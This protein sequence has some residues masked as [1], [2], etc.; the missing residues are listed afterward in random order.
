MQL[1]QFDLC[2]SYGKTRTLGQFRMHHR[3]V[4]HVFKCRT[5]LNGDITKHSGPCA[6]AQQLAAASCKEHLPCP[7]LPIEASPPPS[8]PGL[9]RTR[10]LCRN[11]PLV[12][13]VS[14]TPMPHSP[15]GTVSPHMPLRR[16]V[17]ASSSD[18]YAL[19]MQRHRSGERSSCLSHNGGSSSTLASGQAGVPRKSSLSIAVPGL[20]VS[21]GAGH[22]H[23][24]GSPS[25]MQCTPPVPA[26]L[27]SSALPDGSAVSG[28][29]PAISLSL[30][31]LPYADSSVVTIGRAGFTDSAGRGISGSPIRLRGFTYHSEGAS[32]DAQS[33]LLLM[34][35]DGLAVGTP[36]PS[37]SPCSSPL[38]TAYSLSPPAA[39]WTPAEQ[40][41][42]T[43]PTSRDSGRS[44]S[45]PSS[46]CRAS[47][48]RLFG[49]SSTTSSIGLQ[50][51]PA[52]TS[53]ACRS[54]SPCS[55]DSEA[56]ACPFPTRAPAG[57]RGGLDSPPAVLPTK[58]Y[59]MVD[60]RGLGRRPS[61]RPGLSPQ[62]EEASAAGPGGLSLAGFF[63]QQND[64]AGLGEDSDGELE[65][66]RRAEH[67]TALVAPAP[68]PRQ[69]PRDVW[70]PYVSSSA[71]RKAG[72]ASLQ[73][74][75]ARALLGPHVVGF[76]AGNIRDSYDMTDDVAAGTGA[77]ARVVPGVRRADGRRVAV[78]CI[79]KRYLCTEPE[80]AA[81]TREAE[82]LACAR[83]ERIVSML[84]CFED[85]AH[86]Y[87]VTELMPDGDLKEYIR[88]LASPKLNEHV[89]RRIMFDLLSALA[90][91]HEMGI[92]H[93][94]IKPDNLCLRTSGH[95]DV[96]A[97][98]AAGSSSPDTGVQL[99]TAAS[100]FPRLFM[101]RNSFGSLA[102]MAAA[103]SASRVPERV[104]GITLDAAGGKR[105][106]IE[107]VK[108][109]D[110]GAAMWVRDV[111]H[112][113][114]TG[115]VQVA[116]GGTVQGTLMYTAPEI[117]QRQPFSERAD[118]WSAG[119]IMY[120]LLTG[121]QPYWTSHEC[122]ARDADFSEETWAAVSE[123]AKHLCQAMMDRNASTRITSQAALGHDWFF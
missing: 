114:A 21:P 48:P 55:M 115:D 47:S 107:G 117:L 75:R 7:A 98:H 9:T 121:K 28:A 87:L 36:A 44:P 12:D 83:H 105:H 50:M 82:I 79:N 78:K 109:V 59:S 10:S 111:K 4:L 102:D 67:R 120:Q 25:A 118:V 17:A 2:L 71:Q 84:E 40:R 18:L 1:L 66:S 61:L 37:N 58:S 24:Q 15:D 56:G 92:V 68:A 93:L 13:H 97:W 122:L 41:A 53:L 8:T 32:E 81:V 64:S 16:L 94:D 89:V 6:P 88:K 29:A 49:H 11:H 95:S 22:D 69:A 23:G 42:V 73:A 57:T 113:Q 90:H 20:A 91:L 103:D 52:R 35:P 100:S 62:L 99:I 119:V 106:I 76:N 34:P 38:Q 77:Y 30:S 85:E 51:S 65:L 33:T 123:A 116:P 14:L 70:E 19:A 43:R 45:P 104:V 26:M 96:P 110:L 101:G 108:V 86:A 27:G 112:Y 63:L 39:Q 74:G 31:S 54:T 72:A 80:R 3:K 60:L 46:R 5:L